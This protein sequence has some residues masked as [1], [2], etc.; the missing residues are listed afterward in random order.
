MISQ[1]MGGM[2]V[3]SYIRAFSVNHKRVA[4]AY[5]NV[6]SLF[7]NNRLILPIIDE[8]SPDN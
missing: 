5:L 2:C 4:S 7:T 8:Q 6:G 1:N 3:L